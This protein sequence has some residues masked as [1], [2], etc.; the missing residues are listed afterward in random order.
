MLLF[1][2]LLAATDHSLGSLFNGTCN[3]RANAFSGELSCTDNDFVCRII[4]VSS[5]P[6][7]EA[8][9]GPTTFAAIAFCRHVP[10]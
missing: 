1:L 4:E 9:F 6:V 5:D 10:F 3:K 2:G 7:R 8:G